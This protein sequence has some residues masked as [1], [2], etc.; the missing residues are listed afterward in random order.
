[1]RLSLNQAVMMD[2]TVDHTDEKSNKCNQSNYASSQAGNLRTDLKIHRGEKSNKCN[3][4]DYASSQAT[5]LRRH[6]KKHTE[7]KSN[8]QAGN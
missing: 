7:E 5:H 3:Q 2:A 1:M 6:M 8:S 4:C